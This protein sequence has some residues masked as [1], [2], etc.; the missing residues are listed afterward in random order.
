VQGCLC[1]NETQLAPQLILPSAGYH[2]TKFPKDD[3]MKEIE[4][5]EAPRVVV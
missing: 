5:G 2:V 3:L 1:R 4:Q